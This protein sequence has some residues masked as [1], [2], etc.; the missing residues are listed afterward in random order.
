MIERTGLFGRIYAVMEW[1]TMLA[2]IN[3]LWIFFTVVGLFFLGFAPA[4]ISVFTITRQWVKGNVHLKVFK[5]FLNTYKAE[6]VRSNLLMWP[7]F[8]IAYILYI[9]FQYLAQLEDFLYFVMLFVFINALIIFIVIALYIIPIYIH[10]NL[11]LIQNFK[12]AFTIGISTP[13]VTITMVISLF[14]TLLVLERF[15]GLLP[16]FSVSLISLVIMW[17]ANRAILKVENTI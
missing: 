17:Y 15:P 11:K 16:F 5:T 6:F 9:D 14:I 1:I 13:F 7:I 4:T 3:L 10:Y 8:V 2:Y 12:I